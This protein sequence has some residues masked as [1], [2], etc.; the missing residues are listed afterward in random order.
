MR[1]ARFT[2]LLLATAL[3]ACQT[4]GLMCV[5]DGS[6]PCAC[7]PGDSRDCTSA[8]GNAGLESCGQAGQW[9]TC[10]EFSGDASQSY[11]G[12][13]GDVGFYDLGFHE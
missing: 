11:D 8:A 6:P 3:T 7:M 1:S 12:S 10:A 13:N 5:P 4:Y 2:L 9:S